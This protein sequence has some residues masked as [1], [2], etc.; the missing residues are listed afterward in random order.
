MCRS[1]RSTSALCGTLKREGFIGWD[2][3]SIRDVVISELPA[4]HSTSVS[5]TFPEVRNHGLHWG[6]TSMFWDDLQSESGSTSIP[7][8]LQVNMNFSVI[9]P[10]AA[11]RR[12]LHCQCCFSGD[13]SVEP[14]GRDPTGAKT[15]A[16]VAWIMDYTH[17]PRPLNNHI[18][19]FYVPTVLGF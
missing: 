5:S 12:G 3:E 1:W 14:E 18:L 4:N 13:L 11:C 9:F 7:E 8:W 19:V 15:L 17:I 10:G 2:K 6:F 16:L